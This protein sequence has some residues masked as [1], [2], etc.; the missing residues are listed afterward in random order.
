MIRWL[1]PL[2]A[3]A[4]FCLSV[5]G[6][7]ETTAP[8]KIAITL[9]EKGFVPA[10]VKVKANEKVILVFTRKIENTCAREVILWLSDKE[11]LELKLPFDK[12]VGLPVTFPKAGTLTYGCS[13][14]MV[15]G[16]VTVE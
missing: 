10:N 16:V 3:L 8:R 4:I 5:T 14:D 11:K 12:A 6:R 9:T 13:M 7:A 2:L 15:K 1:A